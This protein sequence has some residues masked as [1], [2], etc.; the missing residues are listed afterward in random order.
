VLGRP[1]FNRLVAP[2]EEEP[3]LMKDP[4][5]LVGVHHYQERHTPDT[6]PP[7]TEGLYLECTRCGKQTDAPTIGMPG[8][9]DGTSGI[10]LSGGS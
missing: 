9:P 4:R 6:H 1:L 3:T 8:S 2:V 5:C 7:S 10:G